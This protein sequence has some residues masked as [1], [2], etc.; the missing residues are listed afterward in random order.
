MTETNAPVNAPVPVGI[1]LGYGYIKA[2][3]PGGEFLFPALTARMARSLGLAD[4]F[5]GAPGAEAPAS[6]KKRADGY[7]VE[8]S[9]SVR[10]R[11]AVGSLARLEGGAG[12]GVPFDEDRR[13]HEGTRVLL[14]VAAALASGGAGAPLVV[15]TGMPPGYLDRPAGEGKTLREAEEE[16]LRGFQVD[17]AFQ[18]GPFPG[19]VPVRVAGARVF[20]QAAGGVFHAL[21]VAGRSLGM[22]GTGEI[23]VVDVG[24]KTTDF[25][26]LEL[27]THNTAEGMS[28]SLE[29]GTHLVANLVAEAFHAATGGELPQE[30][31]EG[32]VASGN[33]Q[34]WWRGRQVDLSQALAE[35]REAAATAVYEGLRGVWRGRMDTLRQILVM[36]GGGALLGPILS[37]RTEGFCRVMPEP[38]MANAKGFAEVARRLAGKRAG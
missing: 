23:G 11:F 29:V 1:D 36:G 25:L 27:E 15:A 19:V 8:L 18:N 34:A 37:D 35:A 10:G 26:V 17:V 12:S 16:A 32:V 21:S 38:Q 14:A 6:D 13:G 31:A 28:G 22:V 30:F 33:A 9:G 7:R 2:V 24:Y 5:G 20:P 4:I 3:G